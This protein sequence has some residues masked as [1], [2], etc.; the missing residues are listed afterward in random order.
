MIRS[1]TLEDAVEMTVLHKNSIKPAWPL[2]DMRDHLDRDI[3][4]GIGTP[5]QAFTIV[6]LVE[7]QAEIL[8]IVTDPGH[9]NKGLARQLLIATDKKIASKGG[10][11]I[12]LEV[13]EDNDSAIA[14][15]RSCAYEP[16]GRRP[17]YYKRENGRVA[18]LTFRKRLDASL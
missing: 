6:R 11:I 15:Y 4:L 1:L 8:T 3:C 5:M 12:F 2:E 17:A 9:R 16:F 7:D 14:L 18:A 13:A 10:E